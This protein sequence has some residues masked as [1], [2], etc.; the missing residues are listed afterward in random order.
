LEAHSSRA[1]GRIVNLE[2]KKSSLKKEFNSL[3]EFQMQMYVLEIDPPIENTDES[4][5][6]IPACKVRK[7]LFELMRNL[8]LYLFA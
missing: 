2:N 3:F 5:T 4:I 8:L 7:I 1:F 6:L